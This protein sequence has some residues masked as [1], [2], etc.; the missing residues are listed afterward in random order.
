[1]GAVLLLT[2]TT[3]G[4]QPAAAAPDLPSSISGVV[5]Y[6]DTGR[7]AAGVVV[8]LEVGSPGSW[9]AA[10]SRQ[11][12]TDQSG[13][14]RFTDLFRG[15]WRAA[16]VAHGDYVQQR[17]AW[18][19]VTS[20][21]DATGFDVAMPRAAHLIGT[22][23]DD[24]TGLPVA[25]AVVT[26]ASR[27]VGGPYDGRFDR[28]SEFTTRS[29]AD[30]TYDIGGLEAGTWLLL[31]CGDEPYYDQCTED[32]PA[33]ATLPDD[34]VILVAGQHASGADARA[35]RSVV[36]TGVVADADSGQ[37]LEGVE[38]QVWHHSAMTGA[39]GRYRI[40]HLPPG[41]DHEL[42]AHD[43][44]SPQRYGS[45]WWPANPYESEPHATVRGIPGS[46][47][48]RDFALHR[49]A[50][51]ISGR[52]LD[53]QGRPI[54]DVQVTASSSGFPEAE[55][56]T[57]PDGRYLLDRLAG[58]DFIV[59]FDKEGYFPAWGADP[60]S[61]GSVRV[62][63]GRATEGIDVAMEAEPPTAKVGLI[64]VRVPHGPMP[65][66]VGVDRWVGGQWIRYADEVD[67]G[68]VTDIP[69][70][71]GAYRIVVEREEILTYYPRTADASAARPVGVTGA[72]P[73]VVTMDPI[74]PAHLT[75]E[76]RSLEGEPLAGRLIVLVPRGSDHGGA[77]VA[78]AV[79][80]EDGRYSSEGLV[81]G[82]YRV[83]WTCD[84]VHPFST[85]APTLADEQTMTLAEGVT[86][87][88]DLRYAVVEDGETVTNRPC[89]I[90]SEQ[91]SLRG[92]ARVGKR[93]GV[94]LGTVTPGRARPRYAWFVDGRRLDET[95]P[96]LRLRQAYRGR[97]VAVRVTWT[98]KDFPTLV[99]TS[100]ARRVR[101]TP[102]HRNG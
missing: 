60:G 2:S 9:S 78:T 59:T 101:G 11:T 27:R 47:H 10:T 44:A 25:G 20:D 58:G 77:V 70:A 82:T 38:V 8:R 55:S 102:P 62:A 92:P 16:A 65:D 73:V 1:M 30:G 28:R 76:I 35:I 63:N 39:D 89:T 57:G 71:V 36:V 4:L 37:P 72:D 75:G 24:V 88:H 95:S 7:P 100:E 12:T 69:A 68:R 18:A 17:S 53:Q 66:H 15:Y 33:G 67:P 93:L 43:R 99:L 54:E 42:V 80:G 41:V 50:G 23:R 96:R 45:V 86:G 14:Y 94:R 3:L 19:P 6:A 87:R 74:A 21:T 81:P 29:G 32:F 84:P 85:D 79:S 22:V 31:V 48:V 40:G 56:R 46:T 34:P 90:R 5:T 64:R 61:D 98:L 13:Q 91:P 49:P 51:A 97:R 52:V 26:L 83:S